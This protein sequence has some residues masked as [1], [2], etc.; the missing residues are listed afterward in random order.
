MTLQAD[1]RLYLFCSPFYRCLASKRLFR[2]CIWWF[3][4]RLSSSD[5]FVAEVDY[6]SAQR[7]RGLQSAQRYSTR[8]AL[9][10]RS[11]FSTCAAQ[12]VA[13]GDAMLGD[14]SSVGK[15]A[16]KAS[17]SVS[18]LRVQ[19]LRLVQRVTSSKCATHSMS[20]TCASRPTSSKWATRLWSSKCAVVSM[21]DGK[22]CF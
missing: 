16:D 7:V 22:R 19:R 6:Q 4:K 8:A 14:S 9:K 18:P 15:A 1:K 2:C 13:T 3:Y 5:H 10:A 17:V 12:R 21:S 20:S 11:K